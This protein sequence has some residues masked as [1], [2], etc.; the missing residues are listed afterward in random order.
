MYS[1][2]ATLCRATTA[3]NQGAKSERVL[4]MSHITRPRIKSERVKDVVAFLVALAL[5]LFIKLV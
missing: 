4:A 5:T 3:R 1:A 2:G